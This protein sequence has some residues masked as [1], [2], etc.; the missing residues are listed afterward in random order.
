MIYLL[1]GRLAGRLHWGGGHHSSNLACSP[2]RMVGGH[3]CTETLPDFHAHV[4]ILVKGCRPCRRAPKLEESNI[5]SWFFG[6]LDPWGHANLVRIGFSSNLPQDLRK[7]IEYCLGNESQ[8]FEKTRVQNLCQQLNFYDGF[9]RNWL[10]QNVRND[11][12]IILGFH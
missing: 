4:H 1:D 9:R 12:G 3:C 7:I 6:F 10:G 5:N 11:R 2:P 8:T